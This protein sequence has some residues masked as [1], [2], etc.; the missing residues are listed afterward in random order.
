MSG[1]KLAACIAVAAGFVAG[2]T[3]GPS[4]LT[5]LPQVGDVTTSATASRSKPALDMPSLTALLP[6]SDNV[7]GSSTDVYTRIARGV[8][9]CWFGAAGPLKST[10]V[11]HAEAD[12]A[13]KGGK[14]E[15]EIFQKDPTASDPRSLRAY[16]VV[17]LPSGST[18]KVEIENI[19]IGEPLASRLG[20]DVLRWSQAE[21]GCGDNPVTGGWAAQQVAPAAEPPAKKAKQK[22]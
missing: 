13:S 6:T 10:H 9:T 14:S 5:G 22:H 1:W 8:L 21:G 4:P 17:I 7:V 11:Y 18:A 19:K 2:C 20:A 15:I 12:P 3:N 16:R